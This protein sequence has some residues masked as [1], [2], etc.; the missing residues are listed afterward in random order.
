M[1]PPTMTTSACAGTASFVA[2]LLPY[3]VGSCA[4]GNLHPIR[5]V[6]RDPRTGEVSLR[7]LRKTYGRTAAVHDLSLDIASGEFFTLLGPS[8]SGKSTTL[9]I[10]AGFVTPDTGAVV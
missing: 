4:D 7:D 6:S 8:G 3:H 10:I 9:M 2:M 5:P 1:P